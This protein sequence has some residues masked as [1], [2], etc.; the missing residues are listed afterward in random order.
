[1]EPYIVIPL[2]LVF[3]AVVGIITYA[4]GPRKRDDDW[5]VTIK[6]SHFILWA[7]VLSGMALWVA[8]VAMTVVRAAMN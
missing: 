5:E 4:V 3:F 7:G 8:Y 1:M 6:F 2:T